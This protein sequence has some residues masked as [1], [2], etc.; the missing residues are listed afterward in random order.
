MAG[1]HSEKRAGGRN[2]VVLLVVIVVLLV[3]VLAFVLVN[4]ARQAQAPA[5]AD[6]PLRLEQVQGSY[7]KPET[8]VDRSRNVTL[9]GWGGFTIPAGTTD[10]TQGFEFHNPAEN[11]WYEDVVSAGGRELEHLVVD[12]GAAVELDH[13]LALAGKSGSVAEVLDYDD[14]CFAVAR[15]DSG[16]W[17]LEGTAGFDGER[18]IK[19]RT[20]AGEDV[21]LSVACEQQCYY[22]TFS[23]YLSE[24]DELLYQSGLVAPGNY[25][26]QM[27]MARALEPGTYDA[28]VV[29]QP[30]RSDRATKTNQ[31]VV[32]IT[33]TAA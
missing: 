23:L 25:V 21:E 27:E 28:Y 30:Y 5:Q 32:R 4:Q 10:I 9:P 18:A 13:Y 24:G 16:A 29:C 22:M 31:G 12:S 33:L 26:Q 17:T 6:A 19:V 3:A 8:P 11:L 15:D 14:Q 1:A 20:D 2:L 7:V